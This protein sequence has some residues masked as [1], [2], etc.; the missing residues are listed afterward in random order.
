MIRALPRSTAGLVVWISDALAATTLLLGL[1][2]YGVAHEALEQQLDHRVETEV[3]ALLA[4]HE[5]GGS[6]GIAAAV[7]RRQEIGAASGLGYLLTDAAGHRIAGALPG[8]PPPL[9]YEEFLPSRGP[10]GAASVSQALTT[11]TP[12]GG[13]LVVA[14][15]RTTIE[16]IDATIWRVFAGAFGGMLLVGMAGAWLIGAVTRRRLSRI[17]TTAQAIID[18]DLARRIPRDRAPNEFDELAATLNRMLDRNAD[19]LENLQQ[20]SSDIAH[21]LRTPLARLQQALDGAVDEAADAEA[22]RA[23]LGRASAHAQDLLD[24]FAALL[25]ISEVESFQ[26]RAAFRPVSLSEIAERCAD[27]FRPDLEAAGGAFTVTI[28]PEVWVDGDRHLLAQ[29]L[30][31]LI[32]NAARHTPA[33]ATVTLSVRREADAAVLTVADDG[34]GIAPD[35][36]ERVLRRFARLERSRATPG[37]GLGLSLAAAVARAHFGQLTLADNH[38]GLAVALR[39]A[40]RSGP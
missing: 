38:P 40:S 25:R 9:G 34:P 17:N 36:R 3:H 13:R 2:V 14:A 5:V 29:L 24:L 11:A 20:V 4:L 7:R 33:G 19:L 18:G 35:D 21:D 31:N 8:P 12:E 22:L 30:V 1:A 32:E 37:H 26:V 23:A 28:E 27:A 39:L 16:E 6:E 15:D 10:D